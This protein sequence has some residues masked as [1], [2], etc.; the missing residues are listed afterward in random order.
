MNLS[1]NVFGVR[2]LDLTLAVEDG[3]ATGAARFA[4]ALL[5]IRPTEKVEVDRIA[6]KGVRTLSR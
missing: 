5:D 4:R 2:F 3:Y 1:I 6:R